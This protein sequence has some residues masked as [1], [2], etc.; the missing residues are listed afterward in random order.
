MGSHIADHKK[1][2]ESYT[3]VQVTG[4]RSEATAKASLSM[5]CP[6]EMRK[7]SLASAVSHPH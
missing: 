5:L 6:L 4:N 2:L 7:L 1:S 3:S